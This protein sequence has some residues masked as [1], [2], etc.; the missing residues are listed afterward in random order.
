VPLRVEE[1]EV[2]L[3]AHSEGVDAGAA[4]DQQAGT[5]VR[6]L[7]PGEAAQTG[8]ETGGDWV[9]VYAGMAIAHSYSSQP[10]GQLSPAV[11]AL[12]E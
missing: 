5:G 1:V 12:C 3:E 7:E 10:L 11:Y 9:V 8:S 4:R 2:E 6:P